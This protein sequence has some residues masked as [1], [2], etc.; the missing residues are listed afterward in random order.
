MQIKII[1]NSKI[2]KIKWV[3][4]FYKRKRRKSKKINNKYG[5]DGK[6]RSENS[7]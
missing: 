5:R 6:R 3:N 7:W 2:N 1:N 4:K